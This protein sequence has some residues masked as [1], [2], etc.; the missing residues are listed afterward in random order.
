MPVQPTNTATPIMKSLK[1]ITQTQLILLSRR[2]NS[3]NDIDWI[4]DI[5]MSVESSSG[6]PYFLRVL[7][8]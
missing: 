7:S 3:S 4:E 2:L 5:N 8:A 1:M 6:F